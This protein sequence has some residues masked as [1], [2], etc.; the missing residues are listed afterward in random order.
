MQIDHQTRLGFV[1][2]GIMGAPIVERLA[3]A[4]HRLS[5]WNREPER[6]D[7]VSRSGADWQSSPA[8]VWAASDVVFLCV[9][10]D[11]AVDD[12]VLGEQG[13]AAAARHAS[14][15]IDLS[16]TSVE[17]TLRVAGVLAGKTGAGWV[18]APMSGGPQAAREGTLTLMTGGSTDDCHAVTPLL[19][20]IA[21]NVTRMGALGAGQKTKMLNQAAVGV[22][23]MLM[24]ELLAL[25]R[26]ADIDPRRLPE[27]LKGGMADSTTLQRILPQM[28]AGDFVPPRGTARQL[29]K[30]L[31]A[32]G[33]LIDQL[34]LD[35]PVMRECISLY[36][37]WAIAGHD[38]VDSAAV[39]TRY[40]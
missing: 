17:T 6:F 26:A 11:D 40:E 35:L 34:A 23:Y 37:A 28:A 27:C 5:V 10:G 16:T 19:S 36:H 33:A 39:C 18:D 13:F 4:G 15:L 8:E 31:Q 29:D 1:G 3:E 25:S 24:A 9:L 20:T 2:L 32:V 7:A 21:G 12:C 14:I 22:Q 38:D 30:D